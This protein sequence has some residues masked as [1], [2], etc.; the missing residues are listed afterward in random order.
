VPATATWLLTPELTVLRQG[1]GRLSDPYPTGSAR[2][3]TPQIFIGVVEKTFRAALGVD[4]RQGPL[5]VSANIGLHHLRD[6]GHV[7]GR[8][9]TEVEGHVQITIGVTRGG[10]LK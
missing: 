3:A 1:E 5:R 8:T 7:E 6:A 9:K 4:G 10:V 2:G